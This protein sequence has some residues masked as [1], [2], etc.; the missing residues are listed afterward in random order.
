MVLNPG[1]AKDYRRAHMHR[2]KT[3]TVDPAV[4]YDYVRRMPFSAS[5]TWSICGS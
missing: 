1:A 2:S 3:D 5:R 4:L